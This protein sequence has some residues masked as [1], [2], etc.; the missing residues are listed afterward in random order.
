MN[1]YEKTISNLFFFKKKFLVFFVFQ[2]FL[3][4]FMYLF[5]FYQKPSA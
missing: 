1:I 4:C 5:S 3:F 2:F